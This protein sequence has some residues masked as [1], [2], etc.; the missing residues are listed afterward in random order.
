MT[1]YSGLYDTSIGHITHSYMYING[2]L[3]EAPRILNIGEMM[4]NIPEFKDKDLT[5]VLQNGGTYPVFLANL[6]Y[7]TDISLFHRD[8]EFSYN[9]EISTYGYVDAGTGSMEIHIQNYFVND[10]WLVFGSE[11]D[12]DNKITL[13]VL[14]SAPDQTNMYIDPN[15]GVAPAHASTEYS[16][17]HDVYYHPYV[18]CG[19]IIGYGATIPGDDGEY[20]FIATVKSASDAEHPESSR[21]SNLFDMK[22]KWYVVGSGPGAHPELKFTIAVPGHSTVEEIFDMTGY[23]AELNY[24]ITWTIEN[25]TLTIKEWVGESSKEKTHT[26]DSIDVDQYIVYQSLGS[27]AIDSG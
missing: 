5:L 26:F 14:A 11:H 16:T 8:Y 4:T 1:K 22:V 24:S 3:H 23:S 19:S 21:E 7:T 20:S 13:T 15:K 18:V 2:A 9:S 6:D 17:F 10:S 25:K 27:H 12:G